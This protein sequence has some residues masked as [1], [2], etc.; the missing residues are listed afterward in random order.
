MASN[1]KRKRD[2]AK[3]YLI[4]VACGLTGGKSRSQTPSS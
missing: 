3:E 1:S 4:R 2:Y